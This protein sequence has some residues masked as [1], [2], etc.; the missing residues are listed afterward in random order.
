MN[1]FLDSIDKFKYGI[2]AAMA[3]YL[4]IFI[5][6]QSPTVPIEYQISP[7]LV[8]AELEIPEDEIELLP[9]NITVTPRFNANQEFV[10]ATRDEN[11]KRKTSKDKWSEQAAQ[12]EQL[13]AK[14]LEQKYFEETGGEAKR[15][16]ILAEMEQRKKD[17]AAK[18][19][20]KNKGEPKKGGDNAP[21][22]E[23]NTLA[24]FSLANRSKV[25]LEKPSYMGDKTDVGKI[26]VKIKVDQGG[27]VI[28]AKFDP[29]GSTTTN[30]TMVDYAIEFALKS[31][32]NY[33]SSAPA[34]QEGTITYTYVYQ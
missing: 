4:V 6:V 31:K 33:S 10:N 21:A 14:E 25:R 15:E 8:E 5:Y 16:K 28:D 17:E 32:F 3:A 27:T 22:P 19:A 12:D 7:Y 23:I 26:R 18:N 1:S 30:K 11:D 29:T 34:V 9:E 13:S 2:F 24:S 20:N